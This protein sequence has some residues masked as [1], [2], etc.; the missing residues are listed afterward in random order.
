MWKSSIVSWYELGSWS[1]WSNCLC[2]A[3]QLIPALL[4]N[5]FLSAAVDAGGSVT[6]CD[7]VCL[8]SMN[9]WKVLGAVCML[10][11]LTEQRW[12]AVTADMRWNPSV[13]AHVENLFILKWVRYGFQVA[14][15]SVLWW[16]LLVSWRPVHFFLSTVFITHLGR[17][18]YVCSSGDLL[19]L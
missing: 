1:W 12:D 17:F 5:D 9:F 18:N 10:C 4:Q 11:P 6:Q 14:G 3:V 13:A 15:K 8:H 19:W 7:T 2:V 16:I